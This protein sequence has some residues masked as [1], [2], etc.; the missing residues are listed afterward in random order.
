[1]PYP[2]AS[3]S[4]RG[5]GTRWQKARKRYLASHP[6]CVKCRKAGLTV[7][8]TVVDHIQPHR[9]DQELFWNEENWQAIC[10][11]CHSGDKQISEKSGRQQYR[12]ATANGSP[13]DPS[14]PWNAA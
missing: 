9:N 1:M 10:A 2:R 14:H 7:A 8:A 12:G 5:Y 4:S 3:A 6:L 11:T 13:L